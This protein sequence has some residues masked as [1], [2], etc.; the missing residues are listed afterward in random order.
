MLKSPHDAGYQLNQIHSSEATSEG[1]KNE[2][3]QLSASLFLKIPRTTD[4]SQD[5]VR[6]PNMDKAPFHWSTQCHMSAKFSRL[7]C[8]AYD[9]RQNSL[10]P[11]Q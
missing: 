11:R 2:T 5:S 4:D 10:L 9:P 6:F 8:M 1:R 3:N 7:D